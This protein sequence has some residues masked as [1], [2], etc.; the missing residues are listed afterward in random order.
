VSQTEL[1][2]VFREEA[3]RITGALARALG[4]FDLA[5]DAFQEAL[6]RASAS[7]PRDGVPER[8]AAWLTTV[9]RNAALDRLRREAVGRRKLREVADV[10]PSAEDRLRLIFTC[11][12]PSLSRETQLALT[13]RAVCGFSVAQIAAA[14]VASEVAVAQR[15][16]RARRKI[17]N[18]GIPFCIPAD[19]E[20]DARLREIHAVIY[21]MFNEGYLSSTSDVSARTE[22]VD[23]AVWLAALLAALY[24]RDAETI[25]LLALV[26]L[27]RARARGRFDDS[28][29]L[30]LLPEQDRSLWDE[31][32]LAE[33]VRL[34]RRAAALGEPGP[35]QLQAAIV[36]CHA[37]APSF[38][39]TDWPQI[40]ALYDL[41]LTVQP[42][43]VVRL[44][45]A[46]ALAQLAGAA[47]A[48]EEIDTLEAE[49]TSYHLFHAARGRF[50][51]ELGLH[52]QAR[53]AELEAAG[54]TANP[55]EQRLL[56]ARA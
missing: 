20:L 44:N 31:A 32:E 7:W 23:D 13:L 1:T 38:A 3:G 54:L 34:L 29:A 16:A 37:E 12:H 5:E 47:A 49:L 6:A 50:L 53:A 48:L 18:A 26:R 4:S 30:I 43:P 41:L 14:L 17:A 19:D 25:G 21:L 51:V 27:Q 2:A 36:A 22:L 40:V 55:A 52:D 8:P 45:R 24:P 56:R 28:G 15:L 11:C 35:Y 39:D 33:G 9:A 46:I 42:S 10:V